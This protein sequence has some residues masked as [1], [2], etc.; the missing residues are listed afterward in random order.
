MATPALGAISPHFRS[1]LKLLGVGFL[2]LILLIP[3]AMVG[4]LVNERQMRRAEAQSEIARR[5]GGEQTVGGPIIVA[6][7]RLTRTDSD[8]DTHTYHRRVVQLPE[9]LEVGVSLQTEVRYLGIYEMPVYT[10]TID[11]SGQLGGESLTTSGE[12]VDAHVLIPISDTRALRDAGRLELGGQRFDFGPGG[13]VY[14]GLNGIA[15]PLP[16]EGLREARPF[17][18]RLTLAGSDGLYFLPLGRQTRVT[19]T[20]SWGSPGF[21]GHY[22]PL[23]RDVGAEEF[24]AQWEIS[25]LN[26]AYG[27]TWRGDHPPEVQLSKFGVRLIVPGNVY[28]KTD[29]AIKYGILFIGLTFLG[30][31]VFEVLTGVR[32]HPVQYLF[33]GLA[34]TTFYLLLLA[35]SEHLRFGWAYLAG[36]TTLIA[37]VGGYCAA[38]LRSRRRG[39]MVGAILAGVYALLY[40]LILDENYSLLVGS[41]AVI[42]M[43][44]LIMYATRR[45]DWYR[46]DPERAAA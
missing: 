3:L 4:G 43:L 2:A 21:E 29:R 5:W 46:L 1:T 37:M 45:V 17:A 41:I 13:S 16:L 27:Q 36:A 8:G 10:S 35:L 23:T 40:W 30:L 32:L 9:N 42:A 7:E 39:L 24:Q 31:F 28:Q 14:P 20:G 12:F 18:A 11:L 19:A 33:V 25:E 6:T 44:A 38:I 15:I 26:R 22:L 34:L